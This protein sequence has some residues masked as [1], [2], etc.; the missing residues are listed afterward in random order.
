MRK[1]WG[2]D[3]AAKKLLYDEKGDFISA[4]KLDL[5]KLKAAAML[6][7]SVRADEVS[8]KAKQKLLG[9]ET[10]LEIIKTMQAYYSFLVGDLLLP[11][12]AQAIH[13]E[14]LMAYL[15][16]IPEQ[17]FDAYEKSLLKQQGSLYAG[18]YV[19]FAHSPAKI[20]PHPLAATLNY[21]DG[22]HWDEPTRKTIVNFIAEFNKI[23]QNPK[24]KGPVC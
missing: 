6:Q 8:K 19:S 14:G 24:G 23:A 5:D 20:N 9:A 15:H 16:R 12:Y 10:L 7:I 3:D 13:L 21:D 2:E 18:Q 22:R 11:D 17:K 1:I 4:S